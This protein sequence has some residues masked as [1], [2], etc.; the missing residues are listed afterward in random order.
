VPSQLLRRIGFA[1]PGHIEAMMR[2]FL[3]NSSSASRC[4]HLPPVGAS[5]VQAHQR[6]AGAIFLEIDAMHC[7]VDLDMHVAADDRLDMTGHDAGTAK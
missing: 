2:K 1:V 3:A 4:R 7:A 5:G 6:D